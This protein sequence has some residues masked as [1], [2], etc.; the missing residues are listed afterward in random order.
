VGL[1][2]PDELGAGR[3]AYAGAI[4]FAALFASVALQAPSPIS[5]LLGLLCHLI[6]FPIIA[7]LPAPAWAQAAGY[8]WLIIDV[9]LNVAAWNLAALGI[10]SSDL[11]LVNATFDSL[12][13]GIHVSASI[14]IAA[15]SW[16]TPTRIRPIGV[17]VALFLT[18]TALAGLWLPVWFV[19]PGYLLLVV[20]LAL[21][22]RQLYRRPL[23]AA[24]G[25]STS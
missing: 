9:A 21:V 24:R 16:R 4:L 12:R 20:W 17:A 15:A 11:H 3:L 1:S 19:Y 13:Q 7:A 2:K 8:G 18:A 14:W 22:G 23:T 6:L 10:G 25:E 5:P